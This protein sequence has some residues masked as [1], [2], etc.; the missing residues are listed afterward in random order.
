MD[1]Q[2]LT[3]VCQNKTGMDVL[4]TVIRLV[5][6]TTMRSFV[7]GSGM[8][9]QGAMDLPIA[10]LNQLVMQQQNKR[11]IKNHMIFQ[12]ISDILNESTFAFSTWH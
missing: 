12:T 7:M 4:P 10:Q 8:K 9:L 5:I 2:T 1:V 11:S 3:T 6:G